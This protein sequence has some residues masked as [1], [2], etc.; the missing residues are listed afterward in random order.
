M[1]ISM[2]FVLME[3][4]TAFYS[5]IPEHTESLRYMFFGLDGHAGLAP[6]MWISMILA[7]ALAGAA[8]R[9]AIPP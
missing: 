4:F 3:F 1:V 5:G 9:A 8:A 2:F 7:A 6:W